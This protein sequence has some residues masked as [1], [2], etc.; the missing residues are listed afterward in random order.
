MAP[1]PSRGGAFAAD[2]SMQRGREDER[3]RMVKKKKKEK[4]EVEEEGKETR[5][6]NWRGC[7]AE[8]EAKNLRGHYSIAAQQPTKLRCNLHLIPPTARA[9]C[10]QQQRDRNPIPYYTA[11]A[12]DVPME[13]IHQS[14][15]LSGFDI[16]ESLQDHRRDLFTL[17]F[18]QS[19]PPRDQVSSV[20]DL[21]G[22]SVRD[23]ERARER[24]KEGKR[25]LGLK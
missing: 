7:L 18:S 11:Y 2:N 4:E 17:S 14:R 23:V 5:C 3:K 10:P 16:L 25:R 8:K 9:V 12:A 24:E 20:V 22:S 15:T 19:P 21:L 6:V 13:V 1:L